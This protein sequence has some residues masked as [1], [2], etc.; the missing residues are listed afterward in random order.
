MNGVQNTQLKELYVLF[1]IEQKKN[2][3]EWIVVMTLII[4]WSHE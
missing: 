1:P 4:H 3:D 2:P